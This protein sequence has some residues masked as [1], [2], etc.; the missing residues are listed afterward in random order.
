MLERMLYCRLRL[1]LLFFCGVA[2]LLF[3]AEAPRA[4]TLSRTQCAKLVAIGS[5]TSGTAAPLIVSYNQFCGGKLQTSAM[6]QECINLY[7]K[8]QSLSADYN[9]AK[10][11]WTKGKCKRD[12]DTFPGFPPMPVP[13]E[14][15]FE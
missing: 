7:R 3:Q 10:R 4:E 9:N 2:G 1:V 15:A 11:R 14:T 13:P 8:I 12:G 6:K 5:T